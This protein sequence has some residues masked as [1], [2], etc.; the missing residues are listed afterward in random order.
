MIYNPIKSYKITIFLGQ[1]FG[2]ASGFLQAIAER[3]IACRSAG[4]VSALCAAVQMLGVP[5]GFP[6]GFPWGL[7]I[8][9]YPLKM[10]ISSWRTG[11]LWFNQFDSKATINLDNGGIYPWFIQIF[12]SH[13]GNI[14]INNP[15]QGLSQWLSLFSITGIEQYPL[16]N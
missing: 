3:K 2:Q 5:W 14:Q 12:I 13:G 4:E 11:K 7:F 16:V 1:I 15:L 6:W 10:V 8:V 9:G